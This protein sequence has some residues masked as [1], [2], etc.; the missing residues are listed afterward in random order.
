[1]REN[2]FWRYLFGKWWDVIVREDGSIT[3]REVPDLRP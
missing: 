2:T 3:L 1:M